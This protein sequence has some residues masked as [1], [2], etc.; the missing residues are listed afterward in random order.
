VGARLLRKVLIC[1]TRWAVGHLPEDEMEA[2]RAEARQLARAAGDEEERWR[3]DV[4]DL[5]W[6]NWQRENITPYYSV[7]V[8]DEIRRLGPALAAYFEAR[9]EWEAMSEALDGYARML[10]EVGAHHE[11]TEVA[12]RRLALPGLSYRERGDASAMLAKA[13][14][15]A[16]DYAGSIEVAW[17]TLTTLSTGLS[18]TLLAEAAGW[19]ALAACIAGHWSDASRLFD[20]VEEAWEAGDRDDVLASLRGFVAGLH[21]ATAREERAAADRALATLQRIWGSGRTMGA[22]FVLALLKAYRDDD[23][24]ALDELQIVRIQTPGA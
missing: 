19:G 13:R 22:S 21:I 23:V 1:R 14:M 18:P 11:T 20:V 2:L 6:S 16:G 12:R 24:H 10:V 3:L 17:Q 7:E 9:G 4:V 15:Y 5:F 8:E